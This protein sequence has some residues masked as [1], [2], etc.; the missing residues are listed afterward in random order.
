MFYLCVIFAKINPLTYH[1][2]VIKFPY[3]NILT[4]FARVAR[5]RIHAEVH[6]LVHYMD[7]ETKGVWLYGKRVREWSSPPPASPGRFYSSYDFPTN[8]NGE[9]I[10]MLQRDL[11]MFGNH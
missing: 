7:R 9:L 10:V 3:S 8:E 6:A 11:V 1:V 4:Q 5:V 2:T